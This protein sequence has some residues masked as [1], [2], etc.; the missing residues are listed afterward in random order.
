MVRVTAS[1]GISCTE[2]VE[3]ELTPEALIEAADQALYASK[4]AGRNCVHM[5]RSGEIVGIP[6]DF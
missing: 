5:F 2:D 6:G 4:E 1:F 3:G